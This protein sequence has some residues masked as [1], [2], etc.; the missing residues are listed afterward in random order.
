MTPTPAT[1]KRVFA[2]CAHPDDIEFFM[3]GTLI[4][5]AR[6][7]YEMHYMSIADGAC[8]SQQTGPA[9]TAAI[10]LR[11]AAAAA[12]MIGARFH[13][14]LVHDMEILYELPVV[15]R[16]AALMREIAPEILLAHPPADYMEDHMN[17]C[18]MAVTAAFTREMPNFA[19]DPP[20]PI[21]DQ[22]VT[23]YHSQ[24][25]GNRDPLGG[26]VRPNQFV[27]VTSV[28]DRKTAMLELH[29]SQGSWL[30]TTQG[31]SSYVESMRVMS[32][33]VGAMS[34]RF[35]YAEGWRRHLHLGFCS[36]EDDPLSEALGSLVLAAG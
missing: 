34:G 31:R 27:D 10:R 20:R 18:R 30:A 14:P 11:E 7:G 16:I 5:L 25:N 13:P 2:L 33:E 4:L 8:G 22:P 15:R 3:A 32:R 6:A 21:V 29:K 1:A 9:E 26:L 28:I 35:E 36:A 17:A 23:I 19:T 24:P 12:K